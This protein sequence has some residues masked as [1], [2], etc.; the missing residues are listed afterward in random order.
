MEDKNGGKRVK[1]EACNDELQN[2]NREHIRRSESSPR[3]INS[4]TVDTKR[5]LTL[6]T[7]GT[8]GMRRDPLNGSLVPVK[9]YLAESL[10]TMLNGR[11][12]SYK[13]PQVTVI[14]FEPQLDSSDMGPDDWIKIASKIE[15][16]YDQ[17]DGFVV[18]MG[19]VSYHSIMHWHQHSFSY[20][21]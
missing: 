12:S 13:Y 20:R 21:S 9:G 5:I 10:Q 2:D 14:E 15:S 19:T 11:R 18:V 6:L 3:L 8:A 7:G 17:Y 1:I 16:S 4:S